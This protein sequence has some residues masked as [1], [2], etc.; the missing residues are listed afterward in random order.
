MGVLVSHDRAAL[1][2]PVFVL[3]FGGWND[4]GQA[5]T[6]AV[7]LVAEQLDAQPYV[8]ID[9]EEFYDFTVTRP[10]V[11]LTD[12]QQRS[13]EWQTVD[14]RAAVLPAAQRDFVFGWGPEPHFRWRTFVAALTEL[15]AEAQAELVVTL[16]GFLAEV[17]YSRPV[18]VSGFAAPVELLAKAD[19]VTTR[20]E[21][22][23]GIVG[24]LG[25]A[26]RV[27]GIA[28]A[29]LWAALPHY[30]AAV[31]NPR[32][33]LALL[34]RASTLLDLPIDLVP[35]QTAAAEFERNVDAAVEKDP[36]LAAYVRELKKRELAH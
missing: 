23:T 3:A 35:L 28:H 2:R 5:A 11:R 14:L 4:A 29:S 20:Y 21:G 19:V 15:L 31:P 22:P 9:P 10:L 7:R 6:T 8:S 33:A 1:R 12:G 30:I 34:L 27:R 25:D 26:L 32:G 13:I 17:L 16:G 24:V 18:P 36:Q